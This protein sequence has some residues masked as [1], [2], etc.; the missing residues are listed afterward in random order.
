MAE[1][2]LIWF[3]PDRQQYETGSYHHYRSIASISSNEDRFEIIAEFSSDTV[4][5]A[6]KIQDELNKARTSSFALNF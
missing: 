3:N 1:T 2:L 5:V 4:C 6:G